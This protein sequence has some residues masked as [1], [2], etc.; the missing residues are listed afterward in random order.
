MTTSCYLKLKQ[1]VVEPIFSGLITHSAGLLR[2]HRHITRAIILRSEAQS[3]ID[4]FGWAFAC[5]LEGCPAVTH[6]LGVGDGACDEG[7]RDAFS[8]MFWKG[9]YEIDVAQVELGV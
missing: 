8:T 1:P 2:A 6:G 5:D 4:T 7:G 9:A 3:R